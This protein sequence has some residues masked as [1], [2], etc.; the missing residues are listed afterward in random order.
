MRGAWWPGSPRSCRTNPEEFAVNS[1]WGR[2]RRD[3]DGIDLGEGLLVRIQPPLPNLG[4]KKPP[5]FSGGLFDVSPFEYRKNHLK[6]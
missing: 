3:G 4:T 1:Y 5:E 2:P 6:W